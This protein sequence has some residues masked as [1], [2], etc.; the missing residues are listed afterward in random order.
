[1]ETFS[2]G[3]EAGNASASRR[4]GLMPDRPLVRFDKVSKRFRI[5]HE[6]PRSFQDLVVRGF[7]RRIST[8]EFW[9]LR[10]VSFVAEPGISLGIV[11]AN[12]SGKSTLLKLVTRILAPTSGRITVRGRVS[13]L[14]EL[15]AGFHPELSGRDNVFLNASILGMPRREVA[16]R[17]DT[18]VKFADLERF[19]DIPIK[20]YSSGMYARLGFAVAINVEPDILLIDEVLSVGDEAFQARCLEAIQRFHAAG[21]TLLLVS[22]DL[23]AICSVCNEAVWLDGGQIRAQGPPRGVVAEYLAGVRGQGAEGAGRPSPLLEG[24]GTSIEEPG[25]ARPARW[26]SGEAEILDVLFLGAGGAISASVR[27]GDPLTI[28]IRYR[29]LQRVERPVFGLAIST[30][31]GVLVTGPNTQLGGLPIGLIDGE[32]LVTYALDELP[33]APG[34]YRVSASIYDESCTH[35]YD[36]RDNWYSLAV[37]GAADGEGPGIIRWPARWSHHPEASDAEGVR[38]MGGRHE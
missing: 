9:A 3:G 2:I 31:R 11:G 29:A 1:M 37:L 16:A 38:R 17:F 21:K 10:D 30:V 28:C 12:G 24:D 36:Y 19:I 20:H 4:S 18:I 8:E 13:A 22:H 34:E 15:G 25:G 5:Q 33:L 35:P 27:S 32:G 6:R 14:L 23:S 7:R 26:G